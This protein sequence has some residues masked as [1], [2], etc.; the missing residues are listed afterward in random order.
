MRGDRAARRL[1]LPSLPPPPLLLLLLLLP[2]AGALHPEELF[3]YGQSRGDQLLQEGDDE[4]STPV[5]LAS[6]LRFYEAQFGYL[7]VS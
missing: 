1:A 3:P 2:R 5:K 7:Y 4:S 6:P